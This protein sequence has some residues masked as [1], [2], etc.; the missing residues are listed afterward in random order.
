ML[1][2]FVR[3]AV[4]TAALVAIPAASQAHGTR[5]DGV[6][7]CR[8]CKSFTDARQRTA[9]VLSDSFAVRERAP[10]ESLF[11]RAPREAVAPYAR[12]ARAERRPLFTRD[13]FKLPPR[14]PL[15]VRAP[16]KAVAPYT[17]R[18]RTERR[19]LFTRDMFKLP[20]RDPL[21]V[22]APREAVAPATYVRRERAERPA[23]VYR[24]RLFNREARAARVRGDRVHGR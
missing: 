16:R 15:F 13:M 24:D 23:R 20:P 21:F 6:R 22:R 14:D 4:V 11:R 18:A 3:A 10:R 8:I 17:S 2:T 1:K 7:E 19:P 12:R 9:R 5:G